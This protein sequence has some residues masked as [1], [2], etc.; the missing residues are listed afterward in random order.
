VDFY[1]I[2]VGRDAYMTFSIGFGAKYLRCSDAAVGGFGGRRV[3]DHNVDRVEV[4]WQAEG[5]IAKGLAY[6]VW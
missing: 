3:D 5:F 6:S 1:V 2:K 4:R